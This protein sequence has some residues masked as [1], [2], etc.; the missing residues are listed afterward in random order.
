MV[1]VLLPYMTAMINASLRE[2]RLP[3]SHRH[4]VSHFNDNGMMPRLQSAYRRRH[5]TETALVKVLSDIYAGVDEQQ[6]TLLGLLDLSAAFDCV[7]RDI[8][9]QRLCTKFGIMG[10]VLSWIMSFLQ[11]RTQQV[12]Y[13]RCLSEVIQLLFGVP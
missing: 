5:S 9:L 11:D 2:G 4:A 10:T 3:S 6:V 12:F 1:D 7:D 13:K 8:L